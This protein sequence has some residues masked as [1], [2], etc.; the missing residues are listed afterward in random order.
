MEQTTARSMPALS[1]ESQQG[2]DLPIEEGLGIAFLLKCAMARSAR[3][4]G[5]HARE[6]R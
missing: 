6:N 3:A 5:K 1:M 4:S 2:G